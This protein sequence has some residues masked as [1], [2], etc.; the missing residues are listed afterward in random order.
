MTE[1]PSPQDTANKMPPAPSGHSKSTKSLVVILLLLLVVGYLVRQEDASTFKFDEMAVEDELRSLVDPRPKLIELWQT[2]LIP[3][4]RL[5]MLHVRNKVQDDDQPQWRQFLFEE[6]YPAGLID[7]DIH[8]R[9]LILSCLSRIHSTKKQELDLGTKSDEISA[10]AE[11]EDFEKQWLIPACLIQLKDMDPEVRMMGIQFARNLSDKS[12]M[13]NAVAAQLS[14]PNPRLFSQ[15]AAFL[16]L[17]TGQD[18]GIKLVNLPK[19]AQVTQIP[20][21]QEKIQ[22]WQEFLKANTSVWTNAEA[23]IQ[24]PAITPPHLS[25]D[26]MN[27]KFQTMD[28]KKINLAQLKGKVVLLSFWTTWCTPCLEELPAL[29]NIHRAHP[30]KFA[31]FPISLDGIPSNFGIRDE[32]GKFIDDS[33]T[34]DLKIHREKIV[35]LTETLGI[36]MDIVWDHQNRI[37]GRYKGDELPTQAIYDPSGHLVRVFTGSRSEAD[38]MR[39]LEEISHSAAPH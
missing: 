8:I 33:T 12:P 35:N 6:S 10:R 9:E 2:G 4:R 7:P 18:F 30:D 11:L 27:L 39:I 14:D 17:A 1:I 3:Q 22:Q 20:G 19:N 38:W 36:Q 13:V 28:G 34:N 25:H 5:A 21:V 26:Y 32:N 16:Q 29:D 31:I 15:A 23:Q 37:A 24:L